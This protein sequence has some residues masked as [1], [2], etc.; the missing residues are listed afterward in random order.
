MKKVVC[1]VSLVLAVTMLSSCANNAEVESLKKISAM[2]NEA[3]VAVNNISVTDKEAA[4][5]EQVSNRVL[6]DLSTLDEVSDT[7]KQA[8]EA[9]MESVD[10]QLCGQLSKEDYVIDSQY[11]DYL[12]VEFA[13]T[14]FYFQ[15]SAM[16]IK[17]MDTASRSIICD[18]TYSTIDFNKDVSPASPIALGEPNYEQKMAVRFTRWLGI[19]DAKYKTG[20]EANDW[21]TQLTEFET[22][23]GPVASILESQKN[24]KPTQAIFDS[25]NQSTYTGLTNSDIEQ[26][27]ASFVV[28]YVITP[29]YS[30]G[31]NQGY[32]CQHMYLLSYSLNDNPIDGRDVY[33]AEGSETI[34]DTVYYT[35]YSYY[36]SMDEADYSG[37]Y[38]LYDNFGDIDKYFSEY[39]NSTYRKSENFTITLL[40]V[41]GS[42]IECAVTLSDK[43][44]AKGTEMTLPIYTDKIY[45]KLSVVDGKLVI[46]DE[47]LVSR[48]IEG[49]PVIAT[50]EV[51]TTGFTSTIT[52]ENTDK[53]D[54]EKAIAN[55][56]CVQLLK[57]TSSDSFSDIVDTS[58]TQNQL[59][60]VKT[61][62]VSLTGTKRVTWIVSYLQGTSNYASISCKELFQGADSAITEADV[63]YDFINKGNVWYIYNYSVLGVSKLDTKDLSTKNSLC[64][65]STEG[66]ESMTSQVSNTG[67]SS[68]AETENV[69]V[70]Y[71][72]D[73]Y[74]PVLK[75]KAVTN[76]TDVEKLTEADL[77]TCLDTT[78]VAQDLYDNYMLALDPKYMKEPIGGAKL[79]AVLSTGDATTQDK[80]TEILQAIK[81]YTGH[82]MDSVSGYITAED[83]EKLKAEAIPVIQQGFQE[84]AAMSVTG[85][86]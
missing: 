86:A 64:V 69:S 1:V 49:E 32:K 8:V 60:A 48:Q 50:S 47:V 14:P 39:F 53:V 62:M 9:Y 80:R 71:K 20:N 27:G 77:I 6:L 54:L 26:G 12:L 38:E 63:V 33:S 70:D 7:D 21:Q 73:K 79:L 82:Y 59:N 10:A 67:S 56:G 68:V 52:L 31:I 66:I 57:D 15:R 43:V 37:L 11:T 65:V 83:F 25:G 55:F 19:L 18:V 58:L 42:D 78:A 76:I 51:Q 40:S 29:N 36:Q 13:R 74:E 16:S 72:Y 35:L 45:Y 46:K 17:G 28:R 23:Y 22:S 3:N 41:Q 5:Y 34:S 84:L 85:V 2:N 4:I 44:R 81:V 24:V 75:A 30:L 61:S